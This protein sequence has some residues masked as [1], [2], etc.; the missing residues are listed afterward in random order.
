M[1][2]L[3]ATTDQKQEFLQIWTDEFEKLN[4]KWD[5]FVHKDFEFSNLMYLP[6]KENLMKCGILDFQNAFIGFQVGISFL[7]LKIQE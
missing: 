5:S 1:P 2:L 4:F 6:H 3:N 7:F